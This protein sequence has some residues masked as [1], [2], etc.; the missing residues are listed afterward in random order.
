MQNRS[1]TDISPYNHI[2]VII[3]YQCIKNAC[4]QTIA[5]YRR[6]VCF[7]SLSNDELCPSCDAQFLML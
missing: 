4:I 3:M 2:N 5:Y 1:A 6:D 7:P